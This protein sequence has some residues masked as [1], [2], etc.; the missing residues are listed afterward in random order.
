MSLWGYEKAIKGNVSGFYGLLQQTPPPTGPGPND[1]HT[2]HCFPLPPDNGSDPNFDSFPRPAHPEEVEGVAQ[3]FGGDSTEYSAV[4]HVGVSEDDSQIC[5]ASDERDFQDQNLHNFTQATWRRALQTTH[6]FSYLQPTNPQS[7]IRPWGL[8]RRRESNGQTAIYAY[9]NHPILLNLCNPTFPASSSYQMPQGFDALTLQDAVTFPPIMNRLRRES[10]PDSWV[11]RALGRRMPDAN[12]TTLESRYCLTM[13]DPQTGRRRMGVLGDAG[14]SMDY[15]LPLSE[16][17]EAE[18]G[19]STNGAYAMSF[20]FPGFAHRGFRLGMGDPRAYSYATGLQLFLGSQYNSH[21]MFSFSAWMTVVG[22]VGSSIFAA[23][24]GRDM[25]R[26]RNTYEDMTGQLIRNRAAYA[27][28]MEGNPYSRNIYDQ[29]VSGLRDFR[30]PHIGVS[31]ASGSGKGITLPPIFSAYVNGSVGPALPNWVRRWDRF[32]AETVQPFV[33]NSLPPSLN[34]MFG[35]F[36]PDLFLGHRVISID[37]N[38]INLEAKSWSSGGPTIIAMLIDGMSSR[39]GRGNTLMHLEESS[40]LVKFGE[41]NSPANL[42]SAFLTVANR[43]SRAYAR[44]NIALDSSKMI[45]VLTDPGSRDLRRRITLIEYTAPLID[46]IGPFVRAMTCLN[47]AS[48]EDN[49]TVRNYKRAIIDEDVYETLAYLA[50]GSRSKPGAPPG[51]SLD[52]LTRTIADRIA[53]ETRLYRGEGHRQVTITTDHIIRAYLQQHPELTARRADGTQP[54]VEEGIEAVHQLIARRRTPNGRTQYQAELVDAYY[55]N[56]PFRHVDV[57]RIDPGAIGLSGNNNRWVLPNTS[58]ITRETLIS[59]LTS[60]YS[61]ATFLEERTFLVGRLRRRL[62]RNHPPGENIPVLAERVLAKCETIARA[63][64]SHGNLVGPNG[65]PTEDVLREALTGVLQDLRAGSDPTLQTSANRWQRLETMYRESAE[66]TGLALRRAF[67][68]SIQRTNADL[69]RRR[70]TVSIPEEAINKAF[71]VELSDHNPYQAIN[72]LEDIMDE[73]TRTA[74]D[75]ESITIDVQQVV[76][77]HAQT[78]IRS[79]G[80]AYRAPAQLPRT[81]TV[82]PTPPPTVPNARPTA[83]IDPSR[84]LIREHVLQSLEA[85]Y[86]DLTWRDNSRDTLIHE[87]VDHLQAKAAMDGIPIMTPGNAAL[88]ETARD[89]LDRVVEDFV[90]Q[91]S[92]NTTSRPEVREPSRIL[93]EMR[94]FTRG[95]I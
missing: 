10:L 83:P 14:H 65:V 1:V 70:I 79:R 80:S 12:G 11:N 13:P 72:M 33:M 50:E 47:Q 66:R 19:Y 81:P 61:E 8:Y 95:R 71:T 3:E 39:W 93:E 91:S 22:L 41:G 35:R 28:A 63:Q 62:N 56:T 75:G 46:H 15:L 6:N 40:D 27:E 82:N 20:Y 17:L 44:I 78:V 52:L 76:E 87:M 32:V 59:Y 26:I 21:D 57:E 67:S 4:Y 68:A 7:P 29:A 31:A 24:A 16:Y 89:M 36:I 48:V 53:E 60:R 25:F 58:P 73:R 37:K 5:F 94:D 55:Q 51:T 49:D 77:Y 42:L 43:A 34:R 88:T 90:Q 23:R 54:T 18:G 92:R 69:A 2:R 84:N 30:A 64:R 9:G 38:R 45:T 74:R 86:P 85:L